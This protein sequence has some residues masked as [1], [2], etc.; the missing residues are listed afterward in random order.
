MLG[1][2]GPKK[3]SRNKS[4]KA[5]ES[6][7][8]QMSKSTPSAAEANEIDIQ[9]SESEK[10][11]PSVSD[12]ART[13]QSDDARTSRSDDA[14]TSRSDNARTSRSDNART[15]RSDNAR[16]SRSDNARTSRSDDARTSRSDDARTSRSDDARTSRS[17]D[18][19]TSRSD[20]AR[21]SR[22]D[23]VVV[24]TRARMGRP[25]KAE[26]R[27]ALTLRVDPEMRKKLKVRAAELERD[28]SDIV[29][30]L[31]WDYLGK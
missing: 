25:P 24:V 22:S 14:R 8:I 31:V 21:T 23:D 19:R 26:E 20:D 10:T 2:L 9:T 15:S 18:A 3:T 6:E 7:D 12:D 4:V 30:E 27:V 28:M 11:N 1:A 5:S 13:S 16:T 29:S 17:D